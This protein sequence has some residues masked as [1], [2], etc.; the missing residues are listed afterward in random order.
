M[1]L[2]V[3]RCLQRR[4]VA[5]VYAAAMIAVL[6]GFVGVAVDVGRAH[7]T[8]SQLQVLAD[9]A[10]RAAAR[11]IS[12]GTTLAKANAVAGYNAPEGGTITFAAG[13]VVTGNWNS[14][15]KTFTAGGTPTNAVRVTAA[16]TTA[17]GN[18]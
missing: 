16:R 14:G 8:T 3:Q 12:D 5:L 10:A 11:G 9:V 15:A 4:G 6:I 18:A 13:D 1:A 7:F 17:K 2:H